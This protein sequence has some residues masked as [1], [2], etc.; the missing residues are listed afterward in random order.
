MLNIIYFVG[1]QDGSMSK[2]ICCTD[3]AT[4]VQYHVEMK[5][6]SA[7]TLSSGTP[8][9]TPWHVHAKPPPQVISRNNL[10]ILRLFRYTSYR[11][12]MR[13]IFPAGVEKMGD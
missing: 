4:R 12:E 6:E 9:H 8:R 1:R 5:E 13:K 2:G 7:P 10:L 11:K 3:L